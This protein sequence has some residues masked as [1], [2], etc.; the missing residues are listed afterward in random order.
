MRLFIQRRGKRLKGSGPKTVQ[1]PS[2]PFTDDE[3]AKIMAGIE[4][5]PESPPGRRKQ[6]MAFVLLRRYAGLQLQDAVSLRMES[7]RD[8]RLLLYTQKTGQPVWLPLPDFVVRE[9]EG[10]GERQFWNG[11]GTIKP[12]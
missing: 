1:K 4:E 2:I 9:L 6:V 12:S 11:L 8:R 3:L 7:V 5:F 10:L